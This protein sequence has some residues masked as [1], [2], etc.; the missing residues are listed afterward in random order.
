M[1]Q[2]ARTKRL[3]NYP[4]HKSCP[5]AIWIFLEHHRKRKKRLFKQKKKKIFNRKKK[6]NTN[7]FIEEIMTSGE[8]LGSR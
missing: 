5:Q 4:R 6:K 2:I 8:F 7:S 3:I 1:D